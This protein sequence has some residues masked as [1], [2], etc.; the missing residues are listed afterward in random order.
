MNSGRPGIALVD[1]VPLFREGLQ[2]VVRRTP[3]LHWLGATGQLHTAVRLHERLHPDVMLVDS[4]L[5]PQGHLATLLTETD[6]RLAV[7]SLVREPHRTAK[8]VRAALAAGVRGLVPRDGE[9]VEVIQAIMRSFHERIHLDPTLAPLAAGFTPTVEAGTRR[10]LSRREYE[11]LQLIADGLENQ[12]VATELYVSVETVRTHVKN[13]LR[14]LRA[15]DRTHAV[16]LAYQSG[17]L[18]GNLR[19]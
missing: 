11:V 19:A 18:T 14:K 2:A 5:D 15:R 3:G 1:P 16:S 6:P 12:A 9:I 10:S 4:V 13:I 7:V 8:Y 17:L